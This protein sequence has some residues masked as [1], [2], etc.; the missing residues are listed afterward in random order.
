MNTRRNK[1]IQAVITALTVTAAV[2]AG[3]LTVSDAHAAPAKKSTVTVKRAKKAKPVYVK[4]SGNRRDA[5]NRARQLY[6]D[7]LAQKAA[8]EQAAEEA[9]LV[10]AAEQAAAAQAS[11]VSPVGPGNVIINPYNGYA[12]SSVFPNTGPFGPVVAGYVPGYGVNGFSAGG[13]F[14]GGYGVPNG[15]YGFAN[16]GAVVVPYG[17]YSNNGGFVSP[18]FPYGF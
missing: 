5:E 9:R 13:V 8:D 10:A 16:P 12:Q 7:A 1:E 17:G 18:G 3:F 14:G 2:A 15:G 11:T 6:A 4:M